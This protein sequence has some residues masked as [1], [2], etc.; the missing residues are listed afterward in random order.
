MWAV[1]A[2]AARNRQI[3][4]YEMIARA[5]GVP[6]AAVGGF[7]EPIQ[8]F[9][10]RQGLPPLTVLV[11]S[12]ETGMP[13]VGFIAAADIP[14]AQAEVFRHNWLRGR[15]PSPNDLEAAAQAGV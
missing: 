2:V 1:L 6:R 10:I 15:A 12:E 11:V 9:C 5:C 3:L 8:A 13:G 4:S 7:L 14:H